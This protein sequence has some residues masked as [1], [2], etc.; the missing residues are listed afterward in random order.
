MQ[1]LNPAAFYLLGVIPIVVALHF[2]KLRRHRHLVPS[3][4]LWLTIDED[5]RAN[6]PF[7]RLRNLLLPI[8]QV[9]FLLLVIFSAAR[10]ALRKP[11]FIPG[12][13]ILIV[14]N[15]AS[16]LSTETGKER[17]DLAKQAARKHIEEVSTGG[18]IM[19]MV[20]SA[21]ESDAYIREAFTTDTAKLHTAIENIQ[22][23][24][25]PRNLRPVFDAAARYVESSQDK[26]FLISDSF[27]NLPET[28]LAIHKIGVGADAENIGIVRFNVEIVGD[29]YEVLVGVQNFTETVREVAVELAVENA[30]FDSKTVSIP[31]KETKPVLFEGEPEGLVDKVIRVHLPV[32]DDFMLDNSAAAV[33]SDVSRLRIL[34]VSDNENSWL[35]ALL[36]AYGEHVDL[37]RVVPADYIGTGDSAIAIF[38]GGTPAGRDALARASNAAPETHLI[39]INPGSDLP[40][41]GEAEDVVKEVDAPVQVIQTAETHPLMTNVSLQGVGVLKSAYRTLPL[42]GRALVETE[43]GVLIWLAQASGRQ[44]LVFEFDAFN[45]EIS[46]FAMTIPDAPLFVYQSLARFESGTATFRPLEFEDGRTRHAFHTGEPVRITSIAEGAALHVEKP[47]PDKKRVKVVDSVFTETDQV[48]VYTLYAD[49]SPIESFTVNL[50]DAD[51]SALSH[52]AATTETDTSASVENG[53]QTMTQEVWRFP[54]LLAYVLLLLEWWFYHREGVSVRGGLLSKGAAMEETP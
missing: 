47:D 14:D 29:R 28:S 45:P 2:L 38:N 43:E 20:T 23:S 3:I 49:D 54:A 10:P 42:S 6:V 21:T 31:S 34:L 7:Q 40:F 51:T 13:A 46:N 18:G 4:M 50:L 24:H 37:H 39:F 12:R 53:L 5:R 22:Q 52:S 19:L 32:E 8:L 9:L 17:F 1:F 27:E 25:I 26:V 15:S 48:G 44:F 35:P 33:L 11:G 36:E 16:M 30:A 41:I